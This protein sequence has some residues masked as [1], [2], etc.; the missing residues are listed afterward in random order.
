MKRF[1]NRFEKKRI[2]AIYE[3]LN[4]PAPPILEWADTRYRVWFGGLSLFRYP[5]KTVAIWPWAVFS[6]SCTDLEPD[7]AD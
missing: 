2:Q 1:D 3:P 4:R 5:F 7:K 6:A